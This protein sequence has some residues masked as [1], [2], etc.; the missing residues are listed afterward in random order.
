MLHIVNKKK[1]KDY[2]TYFFYFVFRTIEHSR[3]IQSYYAYVQFFFT[4]LHVDIILTKRYIL[5]TANNY[6]TI[7][8]LLLYYYY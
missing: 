1:K 7:Y 2:Q 8:Y 3:T 4:F 6:N 5:A